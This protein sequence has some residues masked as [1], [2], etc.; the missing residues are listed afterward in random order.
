MN[1]PKNKNTC[2]CNTVENYLLMRKSQGKNERK[3]VSSSTISRWLKQILEIEGIGTGS[4]NGRSTPAAA[5]IWADV[6][7]L[8]FYEFYKKDILD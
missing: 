6:S 4:F 5:S 7:G 1:L 3:T 2:V 8:I